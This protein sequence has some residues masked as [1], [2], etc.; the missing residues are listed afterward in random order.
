MVATYFDEFVEAQQRTAKF[1]LASPKIQE[2]TKRL[3]T[4]AKLAQFPSVV[5]D[6]VGELSLNEVVAQCLSIHFRLQRPLEEFFDVPII[7]TI[8]Y[9]YTPPSYLFRQTE[10]ELLKLLQDGMRG[11]QV[12]LHAWLTL[13]SM[14][15]IDLSLATSI[16]VIHKNKE[17]LGGVFASHADELKHGL[18]YHPMLLGTD[19]LERIGALQLSLY[20]A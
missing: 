4:P 13:P 19:Y 6:A 18:R 8:G 15:I 1:N 5:R 17:G 14:E 20:V 12:N 2:P 16:A 9:V 3:L 11:P 10:A 7:F